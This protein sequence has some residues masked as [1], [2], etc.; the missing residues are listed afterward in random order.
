[1]LVGTPVLARANPGNAALLEHGRTGLLFTTA[2]EMVQRAETLL[3]DAVLSTVLAQAA[4]E[5][6]ARHHSARAETEGYRA[7]LQLTLD[8]CC[9]GLH[10]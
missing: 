10:T 4:A 7:A 1:M 8:T 6:V 9:G 2:E 3:A 5:H